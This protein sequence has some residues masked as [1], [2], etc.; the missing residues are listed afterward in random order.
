M[1]WM[2]WGFEPGVEEWSLNPA[3]Y[4]DWQLFEDDLDIMTGREHAGVYMGLEVEQFSSELPS[5]FLERMRRKRRYLKRCGVYRPYIEH[6][7]S[8][9]VEWCYGPYKFPHQML[10]VFFRDVDGDFWYWHSEVY[11]RGCGCHWH[12]SPDSVI[13]GYSE[14]PEEYWTILWNSLSTL[15]YFMTPYMVWGDRFRSSVN[16]WASPNY[17]RISAMTARKYVENPT[18]FYRDYTFLTWNPE[19]RCEYR[20]GEM[21]DKPLTLE[22]RA[23]E[24]HPLIAA[25]GQKILQLTMKRVYDKIKRYGTY[26]VSPKLTPDS[27]RRLMDMARRLISYNEEVYRVLSDVGP[28]EFLPG[29]G[30]PLTTRREITRVRT[31]WDLT[32]MLTH[33]LIVET[34][35]PRRF[36]EPY[37]RA[38]WLILNRGVPLDEG[39]NVWYAYTE[40]SFEWETVP[41]FPME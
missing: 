14:R 1:S 16:H 13:P 2:Q 6:D 35:K 32:K 33:G 3:S 19:R 34:S 39:R 15:G 40:K 25:A 17:E 27:Q 18:R 29:R 23:P 28:F 9:P 21:T 11:R 7:P 30:V 5:R 20:H 36:R 8:G 31:A 12:F 22:F 38:A 10:R 37:S 4:E 24:T 41:P 26:D